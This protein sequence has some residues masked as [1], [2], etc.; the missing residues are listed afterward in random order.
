[1]NG[2]LKQ[3]EHV[4]QQKEYYWKTLINHLYLFADY[5]YVVSKVPKLQLD[6][7]VKVSD[8]LNYSSS[9]VSCHISAQKK[10]DA[11]LVV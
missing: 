5:K 9:R 11:S 2:C 8:T 3:H 10:G 4:Q 1:M 6:S 7:Y